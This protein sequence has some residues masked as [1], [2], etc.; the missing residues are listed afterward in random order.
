MSQSLAKSVIA[1][2]F[3]HCSGGQG[4]AA[5]EALSGGAMA[6]D[7]AGT[8]LEIGPA[9]TIKDAYPQATYTDFGD[10]ILIPGFVDAHL[11]FPQMDMIGAYGEEL[12]GWL[13]K[14][15]FPHEAK[16]QDQDFARASA[17][18]FCR[19]LLANGTTC[20]A[21]FSSSHR[22]ATHTLFKAFEANGLFGVIG[23]TSMNRHAPQEL[24]HSVE[25]D[26][27]DCEQLIT[28]WHGR[29]DR[30]F[31]AISPRFAPSCTAELMRELGKLHHRHPTTYIQTHYAENR[32]ELVWVSQLFPKADD[33]LQV[34]EDFC[35]VDSRTLLGHGI[36]VS[37]A[38]RQRLALAGG[39][40]IHCP[41]SNLFLGSGLFSM[42]DMEQSKIGYALG[43]DIGGGTSF[44]MFA[45]MRAAYEIQKL[46]GY[47]P[48]PAQL[49]HMATLGGAA[50]LSL[51]SRLGNFSPGKVANVVVL[52]WHKSRLLERRLT[53]CQDPEEQLFATIFL[54]DDRIVDRVILEGKTVYA[55]G[56]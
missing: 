31:F 49:L 33:Y 17:Q 35:L 40:I 42:E 18:R 4:N 21:V 24:L 54:G 10:R 51:D 5:F 26:I 45:T 37:P 6:I 55:Q 19:E 34:Y 22:S 44:S 47:T 36:Y 1:G 23:K 39:K 46:R 3:W 50:A 32:D 38:E 11:H 29:H 8:I 25:Q 15:T 16:F 13:N 52:D 7:N 53:T 12:L 41:T 9:A 20:A 2:N 28:Q 27:L 14:Y 43:T 48:R 56:S 30:L